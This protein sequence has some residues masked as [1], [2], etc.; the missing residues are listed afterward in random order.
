MKKLCLLIATAL[1]MTSCES[2]DQFYGTV[3]GAG[4]GGWFG[5]AIGGITGGPRGADAGAV[6]GMVTGAVVGAAATSSENTPP[7]ERYDDGYVSYGRS[8]EYVRPSSSYA[9][10]EVRNLTYTDNDNS[11]SIN[12]GETAVITMD[13]YNASQSVV[14]DVAPQVVCDNKHITVSPTA[15]ISSIDSGKGVR[16][17]AMVRADRKLRDGKA[18]FRVYFGTGRNRIEGKV[19]TL[20]T[21]R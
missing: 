4:L 1:L 20:R 2:M 5:S 13:I 16:Y 21:S 8:S 3:T 17:K 12:A 15:I 7:R 18:E 19:F 9:F 6:I 14:Y 10:L 11:R